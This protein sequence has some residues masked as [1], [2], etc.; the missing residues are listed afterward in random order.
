METVCKCQRTEYMYKLVSSKIIRQKQQLLSAAWWAADVCKTLA[1]PELS[2]Q[3]DFFCLSRTIKHVIHNED[4]RRFFFLDT[5]MLLFS[6]PPKK[7][8]T[9]A[10]IGEQKVLQVFMSATS[11]R[12]ALITADLHLLRSEPPQN[13][14]WR[15]LLTDHFILNCIQLSVRLVLWKKQYIVDCKCESFSNA[16][17]GKWWVKT[18]HYSTAFLVET[19]KETV[20]ES[21]RENSFKMTTVLQF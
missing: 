12:R 14:A 1:G 20:E 7:N 4:C 9:R 6:P 16:L 19:E 2:L 5:K 21:A 11:N 10:S 8:Q 15:S 3:N 17:R 13:P 18:E